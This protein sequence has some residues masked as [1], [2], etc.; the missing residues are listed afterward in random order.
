MLNKEILELLEVRNNL[1]D[2]DEK[3]ERIDEIENEII[4][5]IK[6]NYNHYSVDFI[7][8]TLTKFGQAPNLIYDD[9]G[10]FAISSEGYQP[11]VSGDERIE[12]V[13]SVAVEKEQ[14]FDTI[15]KAL[16]HY[17]QH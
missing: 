4:L 6:D 13:V 7:I 9:N 11:V 3:N 16:W 10:M 8:E 14:W 17:L 1:L 5:Q 15:R 12:G 2:T